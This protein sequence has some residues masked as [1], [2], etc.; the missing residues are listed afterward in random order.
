MYGAKRFADFGSTGTLEMSSF[1]QLLTG[2]RRFG[3][4]WGLPAGG[5]FAAQWVGPGVGVGFGVGTE[6][7]L[8]TGAGVGVA[9]GFGVGAGRGV[10]VD[11]GFEVRLDAGVGVGAVSACDPD[12]GLELAEGGLASAPWAACAFPVGLNA[13]LGGA[14]LP[15]LA[16]AAAAGGCPIAVADVASAPFPDGTWGL[17]LAEELPFVLELDAVAAVAAS[18]AGAESCGLAESPVDVSAAAGMV[19]VAFAFAAALACRFFASA[20]AASPSVW[21]RPGEGASQ[22]TKRTAAA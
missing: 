18:P 12:A 14:S 8:A 7:G 6:V 22:A 4:L 3:K 16:D 21:L 2:K 10:G 9:A 15:R 5:R 20:A 17:L 13:F 19:E 11:T 1:H